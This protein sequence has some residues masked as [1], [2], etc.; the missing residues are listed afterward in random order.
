MIKVVNTLYSLFSYGD[1]IEDKVVNQ[2]VLHPPEDLLLSKDAGGGNAD[3]LECYSEDV[4]RF[5][6]SPG[7]RPGLGSC[8][9]R[10]SLGSTEELPPTLHQYLEVLESGSGVLHPDVPEGEGVP[11]TAPSLPPHVEEVPPRPVVPLKGLITEYP[12]LKAFEG[13]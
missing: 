7:I 9:R 6:L 11:P 5:P 4:T 1:V 10:V 12:A 3:V 13:I 8:R 2:S